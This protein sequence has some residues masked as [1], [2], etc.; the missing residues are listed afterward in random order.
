MSNIEVDVSNMVFDPKPTSIVEWCMVKCESKDGHQKNNVLKR[1][2]TMCLIFVN[3]SRHNSQ[4]NWRDLY[5]HL[6]T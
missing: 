1:D 2:W 3:H 4:H 6:I 5:D